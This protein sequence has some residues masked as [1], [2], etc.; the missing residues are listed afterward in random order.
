GVLLY[1]LLTGATPFD[2][3]R[4]KTASWNELQR[5]ICDEEPPTMSA[6]VSGLVTDTASIARSRSVEPVRLKSLLKGDLDWIV[7]KAIDKSRTRRYGTA[8]EFHDDIGRYL[9]DDPVAATPP[10][11]GYRLK[12]LIRRHRVPVMIGSSLFLGLVAALCVTTSFMLWA[13]R[14]RE[15]A[16]LATRD[17]QDQTRR[18]ERFSNLAGSPFL[19]ADDVAKSNETWG[20]EIQELSL[21]LPP[22][23]PRRIRKECQYATWLVTQALFN[24]QPELLRDSVVD[25]AELHARA[26]RVLG[27]KSTHFLNLANARVQAAIMLKDNPEEIG[28]LLEDVVGSYR[29]NRGQQDAAYT[30]LIMERAL[31]TMLSGAGSAGPTAEALSVIVDTVTKMG[32]PRDQKAAL[33]DRMQSFLQRA[34]A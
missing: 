22:E 33:Q 30:D 34:S 3:Q 32:I 2:Q 7:M 25:L 27:L 6:R 29:E 21:S 8:S 5:M 24:K 13:L 23:N 17:A 28:R 9:R 18:A 26:K 12:K 11:P 31:T 10:T 16:Q 4:V 19:A 20:A 15:R 1:E 14:E